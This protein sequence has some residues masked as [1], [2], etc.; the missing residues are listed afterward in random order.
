MGGEAISLTATFLGRCTP[1]KGQ[2]PSLLRR[3]QRHR[4]P[5]ARHC[6]ALRMGLQTTISVS[7][8][9][10][11]G[12]HEKRLK[13][14]I[15]QWPEITRTDAPA[16]RF[17]RTSAWQQSTSKARAKQSTG[18]PALDGQSKTR[19]ENPARKTKKAP[20]GLSLDLLSHLFSDQ[21][22]TGTGDQ[23]QKLIHIRSNRFHH[24]VRKSNS[25]RPHLLTKNTGA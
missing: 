5:S 25:I 17:K 6:Q 1:V 21:D 2:T 14:P 22:Q 16:H 18:A 12:Q 10:D 13:T 8:T 19:R 23:G 9:T 4:T 24:M 15:F 3:F 20:K 11:L 7:C